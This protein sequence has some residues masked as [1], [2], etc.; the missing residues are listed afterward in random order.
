MSGIMTFLLMLLFAGAAGYGIY[1]Y[2]SS[3]KKQ[4][5]PVQASSPSAPI[6]IIPVNPVDNLK[7]RLL[8]ARNDDGQI[9]VD[10]VVDGNLSSTSFYSVSLTVEVD[11]KPFI[12]EDEALSGDRI[13]LNNQAVLSTT[14]VPSG[15]RRVKGQVRKQD[16]GG[17]HDIGS[18]SSIEVS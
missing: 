17:M 6:P 10:Y 11:G 8:S 7:L 15:Q 1:F 2:L 16:A 18:S 5:P 4:D 9:V 14:G 12:T 13:G 3:V